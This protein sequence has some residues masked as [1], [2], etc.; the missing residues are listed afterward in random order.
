MSTYYS[1]DLF[2]GR[3]NSVDNP[4]SG[5][6]ALTGS[7]AVRIPSG[8]RILDPVDLTDLLTKKYQGIL[9]S[10]AGFASIV[11]DDM[12][13]ATGFSTTLSAGV[14]LGERGTVSMYPN[15]V[16]RSN[17]VSLGI[18]PPVQAVVTFE[19]FEYVD[20]DPIGGRFT[21]TYSEIPS[22]TSYVTCEVSFDGGVSFLTANQD[23]L[24]NIPAPNQGTQFAIRFTNVSTG[25]EKRLHLGSWA[26]LY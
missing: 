24:I 19:L 22:S 15:G 18:T 13:D 25:P 11:F 26:L 8:V 9:S 23:T 7:Y 10:R 1:I 21:R 2:D 14:S 5:Q 3:I 20:A 6:V 16:L 12:Q 4:T 17:L